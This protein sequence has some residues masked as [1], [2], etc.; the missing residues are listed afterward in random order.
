MSGFVYFLSNGA[1]A[2]KIGFSRT[3]EH[4]FAQLRLEQP[5]YQLSVIATVPGSFA[6]EKHLHNMLAAHRLFGEWFADCDA[7]RVAMDDIIAAGPVAIGFRE[8]REPEFSPHVYEAI[9]LVE[10]ILTH[11]PAA[12]R[13]RT[14]DKWEAVERALGIPKKLLW[15]LHYRPTPDIFTSELFALRVAALRAID[16]AVGKATEDR[17]YVHGLISEHEQALERIKQTEATIA[18]GESLLA[19]LRSAS[20]LVDE[21]K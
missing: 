2:I 7:V 19:N 20:A 8:D 1:A 17:A 3:P 11:C 9:R 15:K 21:E 5:Q 10:I 18:E 14:K 12:P 6:L 13:A 16:M 4:R